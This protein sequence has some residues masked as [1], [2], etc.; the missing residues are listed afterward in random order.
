MA[1][2]HPFMGRATD[3]N[4]M[5]KTALQKKE[6]WLKF[7]RAKTSNFIEFYTEEFDNLFMAMTSY[8]PNNRPNIQ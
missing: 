4:I 3:D 7:H 6:N 1:D 2:R 5:F 8:D